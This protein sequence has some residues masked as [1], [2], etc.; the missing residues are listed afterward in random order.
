MDDS[1]D[2]HA[3]PP[4][5]LRTVY[6]TFHKTAAS[7]LHTHPNLVQFE[8]TAST[9]DCS[10]QLKR[11]LDLPAEIREAFGRFLPPL[12]TTPCNPTDG[13]TRLSNDADKSNGDGQKLPYLRSQHYV[14]HEHGE[15]LD[16]MQDRQRSPPVVYEVPDVPGKTMRDHHIQYVPLSEQGRS[17]HISVSL[18]TR[19]TA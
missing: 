11:C 4:A 12:N 5:E 16:G 8:G 10:I 7:S 6:K 15:D 17:V 9:A 13:G 2:A 18:S 1:L 14:L 19:S 3:K